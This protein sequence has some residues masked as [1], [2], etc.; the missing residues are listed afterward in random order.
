MFWGRCFWNLDWKTLSRKKCCSHLQWNGEIPLALKT[1][2][3]LCYNLERWEG[4]RGGMWE[5]GSRGRGHMFKKKK[6]TSSIFSHLQ[7]ILLHSPSRQELWLCLYKSIHTKSVNHSI[8][9]EVS[10]ICHLKTQLSG[11]L[12]WTHVNM[13]T[14]LTYLYKSYRIKSPNSLTSQLYRTFSDTDL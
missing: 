12:F 3:G 6:T 11:M 14:S 2:A 5:G 10:W 1:Q 9:Q 7:K 8:F 4:G 13:V